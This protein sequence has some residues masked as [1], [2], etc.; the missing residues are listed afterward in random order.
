MIISDIA[1]LLKNGF[2]HDEIMEIQRGAKAP[3]SG[4]TAEEQPDN[5]P[6]QVTMQSASSEFET[7]RQQNAE[8]LARLNKMEERMNTKAVQESTNAAPVPETPDLKKVM[9][10]LIK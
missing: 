10:S 2:T 5:K 8:L 4:I 7:L 3:E 9:E 6:D 1:N